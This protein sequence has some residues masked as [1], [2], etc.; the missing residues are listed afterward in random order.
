MW[1][2]PQH[3]LHVNKK[4]DDEDDEDDEMMMMMTHI[5]FFSMISWGVNINPIISQPIIL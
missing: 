2:M 4:S 1:M 3:L 5:L